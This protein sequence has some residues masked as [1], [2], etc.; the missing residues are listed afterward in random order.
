MIILDTVNRTLEAVLGGAV[1]ANELPIVVCYV[2]VTAAAYT[3]ATAHTTTNGAVTVTIAAAPAGATQRQIKFISIR[4]QDTAAVTLT[5]KYDDAAT[6]R[7]IYSVNL[8]VGDTL[9]YSD[10]EGFR[11]LN[12]NGG[13]KTTAVAGGA[14][15]GGKGTIWVHPQAGSGT[16]LIDNVVR[17]S[18]GGASCGNAANDGIL[19]WSTRIPSDFDTLTKAVICC[20]TPS[21]AGSLRYNVAT[22]FDEAGVAIGTTTGSIGSTDRGM[23]SLQLAELD[24]SAALAGLAA[25][26]ILGIKFTRE[27]AHAND[28]IGT[29]EVYGLAIEYT[30]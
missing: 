4:N 2:D 18:Y 10:G 24:I 21:V 19:Y 14:A 29:F 6:E 7:Q 16:V 20:L 11:V 1:A 3:P 9:I 28:T 25:D 5:L 26:D 15:G 13:V 17:D 22:S 27:G 8:D 30:I 23:T 12:V